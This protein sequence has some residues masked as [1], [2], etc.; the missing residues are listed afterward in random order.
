MRQA[1]TV[2]ALCILSFVAGAIAMR[3]YDLGL[4][5]GG[6]APSAPAIAGMR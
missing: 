6:S 3:I 1:L 5:G 4:R 2:V